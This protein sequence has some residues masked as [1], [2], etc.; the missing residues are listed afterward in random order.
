MLKHTSTKKT[1]ETVK[2]KLLNSLMENN[3]IEKP[4]LKDI[5][6]SITGPAKVS[7]M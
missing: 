7:V 3:E 6:N 5:G 1:K 2:Q 4:E